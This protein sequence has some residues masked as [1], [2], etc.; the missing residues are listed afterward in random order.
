MFSCVPGITNSLIFCSIS[1]QLKTNGIRLLPFFLAVI[2]YFGSA[3]FNAKGE[4]WS[5][6]VKCLPIWCLILFVILTK[7]FNDLTSRSYF[8]VRLIIA[9]IFSSLGDL[10][11]N[12]GK[13]EFGVLAFGVAQIF[14]IWCFGF[15]PRRFRLAIALYVVCLVMNIALMQFIDDAL[16]IIFVFIYSYLLVTTTWRGLAGCQKWRTF[17]ELPKLAGAIGAVSFLVSD[18]ILGVNMFMVQKNWLT[19]SVV[20]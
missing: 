19:V 13:F 11:L 9:L 20:S 7:G 17:S 3:A 1:F 5:T 12:I 6:I 4:L 15:Q 10:F 16:T 18:A 8:K 2:G 14:F